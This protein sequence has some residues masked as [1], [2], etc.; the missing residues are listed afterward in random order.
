[1]TTAPFDVILPLDRAAPV[2][3]DYLRAESGVR[4]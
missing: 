3:S 4:S 2:G 1:M